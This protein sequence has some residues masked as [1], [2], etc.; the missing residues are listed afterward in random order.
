MQGLRDILRSLSAWQ[1]WSSIALDDTI[2][3]YRR[4]ILGPLWLVIAQAAFIFGLYFLHR[5]VM[6]VNEGN[7]LLFLAAS[8]PIWSLFVSTIVEGST[9]LLRSKAYIDSF[10]LPMG[11][12]I[13]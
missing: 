5:R 6:G 4:T 8:L 3:R 12:Y 13:V 2:G 9:A 7:Y 10:P 11:I 1:I